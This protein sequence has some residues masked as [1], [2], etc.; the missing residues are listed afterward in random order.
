MPDLGKISGFDLLKGPST[1]LVLGDDCADC[2]CDCTIEYIRQTTNCEQCADVDYPTGFI[3]PR[4]AKISISGVTAGTNTSGTLYYNNGSSVQFYSQTG[5]A[6]NPTCEQ[7]VM[8]DNPSFFNADFVLD[9]CTAYF[10]Y[11][12]RYKCSSNWLGGGF[13]GSNLDYCEWNV[14][15][16]GYQ[17][18]SGAWSVSVDLF[19]YIFH[20]ARPIGTTCS[21][22]GAPFGFNAFNATNKTLNNPSAG[23]ENFYAW[24]SF[25][26]KS[27]SFS[28][29]PGTRPGYF[30]DPAY[31]EPQ[32][33]NDIL[34]GACQPA[35]IVSGSSITVNS[36]YT[37]QKALDVNAA[38]IA[39][40]I[41]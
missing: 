6:S 35:G 38:S 25:R 24:L 2:C 7:D 3:T 13:P 17:F 34:L 40:Q 1:D 4:Q 37:C 28:M 29:S 14:I 39:L 22:I 21:S 27:V 36:S 23:L 31:C 30:Y 18:A 26:R 10:A 5:Q 19:S 32:C 9:P 12:C 41:L 8:A 16:I 15:N 20:N 33:N 11:E